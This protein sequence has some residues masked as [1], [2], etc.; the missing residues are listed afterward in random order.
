MDKEAVAEYLL[1]RIQDDNAVEQLFIDIMPS[2]SVNQDTNKMS[3]PFPNHIRVNLINLTDKLHQAVKAGSYDD[4]SENEA[5]KEMTDHEVVLSSEIN[6]AD[7]RFFTADALWDLAGFIG[8]D[9]HDGK[10]KII[11]RIV[12]YCKK[13]KEPKQVTFEC[14]FSRTVDVPEMSVKDLLFTLSEE[15]LRAAAQVCLKTETI[16]SAQNLETLATTDQD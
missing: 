16:N 5:D 11:N 10:N 9:R 15:Q 8:V 7:F 14:R 12:D 2:E 3:D 6:A 1:E 13:L 4:D